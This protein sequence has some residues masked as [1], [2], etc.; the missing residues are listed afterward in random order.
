MIPFEQPLECLRYQGPGVPGFYAQV[1]EWTLRGSSRSQSLNT[2]VSK[3]SFGGVKQVP[4]L[5]H[6]G[7]KTEFQQTNARWTVLIDIYIYIADLWPQ[8][9]TLR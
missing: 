7:F 3:R 4:K 2:W 6:V 8:T 5:E 9:R 1:S